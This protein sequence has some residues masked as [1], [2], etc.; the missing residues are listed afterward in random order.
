VPIALARPYAG[1]RAF[2]TPAGNQE[3]A[4]EL[5][6]SVAGV[7]THLRTLFEKF[8]VEELPQHQKRAA[9]RAR[10]AERRDAERELSS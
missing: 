8:G 7:K 4:N 9:G 3:I 10:A 2:A 1:G 6:L 5:F